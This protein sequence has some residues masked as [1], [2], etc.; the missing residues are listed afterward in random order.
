MIN[1]YVLNRSLWS[2]E[3][4]L[5]EADMAAEEEPEVS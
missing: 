4:A 1:V 2:A 5:E 3:V